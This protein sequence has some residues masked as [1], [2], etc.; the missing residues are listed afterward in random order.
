MIDGK[1][2]GDDFYADHDNSKKTTNYDMEVQSLDQAKKIFI[3]FKNNIQENK[4]KE[5]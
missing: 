3:E 4:I 2:L 5:N 1:Y